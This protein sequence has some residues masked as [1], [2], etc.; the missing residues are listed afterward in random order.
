MTLRKI[1]QVFQKDA[2]K[3][4]NDDN[5]YTSLGQVFWSQTINLVNDG[6]IYWWTP[7]QLEIRE[8][9]IIWVCNW[10]IKKTRMKDSTS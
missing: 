7:N 10:L 2:T 6:K 3:G 1:L 5:G 8:V 4:F 9:P